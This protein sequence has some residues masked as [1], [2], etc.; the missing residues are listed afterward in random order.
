MQRQERWARLVT[1]L[2]LACYIVPHFLN[3][4]L[5]VASVDAMDR[6]RAPLAAWWRSA[7]G[8]TLLYGALL[9]HFAL[10][11]AS[12]YRRTTLRMPP[13]EA[14]QLVFGLAIPPLLIAHVVGTRFYWLLLDHR[15]TYAR[16]VG[17]LWLDPWAAARQAALLLIV[18][19]HFCYGI[20]Y[21]L[22]IQRWYGS[23]QPLLFAAA[24]LVP[25]LALAGFAAAGNEMR[26]IIEGAGGAQ[27]FFPDLGKMTDDDRARILA[28]RG[29][30]EL[31]FWAL[32]A[33][34]LL[35]RWL[36]T[37]L[38]GT[39]QL[40]HSSGRVLSAPIGRTILE[41]VRDAGLPHASVCG[42]RA[43]CTTCRVRV[44]EGLAEL[45]PPGRAERQALARIEAPVNVRLACQTRPRSNI[46]V[47][48]LLPPAATDAAAARRPG[49]ARESERPVVAMFVD[50]RG[51][52]R[53]A[54]SRLPYDVVF[55]MN[56][57]F[58]EMYAALRA[59]NGY[60]AQ[61]RGDGLLALYGLESD[62]P[63]ACRDA[64]RGAAEMQRRLEI[65]SQSLAAE[66]AEPLRIG[67]GAHAGVAIV[68]TMGPPEAPIYSAIGDHINIAARFEGMT[69]AYHCALVVSADT[70]AHA[71]LDAKG[72]PMHRVKVRGRQE[73]V[74]VYAITDPRKLF[75]S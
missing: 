22:R 16:V 60:Y 12:L 61:F 29:A 6:L 45:A 49:A 11:L 52:T 28:W 41:A 56:Q 38:G 26:P 33:A 70:L 2:V 27:V 8:T 7:P 69:K 65:L 72:A 13:W 23:A 19:L 55:I 4:S 30:L 31:A 46:A 10:A 34:T 18:W 73:R 67:I 44:V 75:A 74:A 54:E 42:G 32:L 59:T 36:R 3:H 66:L 43:R 20:H 68:G 57:F 63:Q 47:V 58:S 40:R 64:M 21:W 37:R 50:L 9:T 53:L 15:I 14:A 35:A 48:P 71:G 1:G 39:Y 5:G 24:I 51:S 17:L 25:S 62:L